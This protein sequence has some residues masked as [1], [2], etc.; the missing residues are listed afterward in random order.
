VVRERPI[1]RP[2]E[3]L[4]RGTVGVGRLPAIHQAELLSEPSLD[5]Q[6]GHGGVAILRTMTFADPD[7]EVAANHDVAALVVL[8]LLAIL[9]LVAERFP[10]ARVFLDEVHDH[11]K[12]GI[13][14]LTYVGVLNATDHAAAQQVIEQAGLF[15]YVPAL[16]VGAGTYLASQARGA[17][18]GPLVEADEDDDLGLQKLLRWVGDLWGGLGPVALIIFPLLTIDVFGLALVPLVL[19]ERRV[20]A[21]GERAKVPCLNCDHSIH[22]RALA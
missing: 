6:V 13:A 20:E 9:E 12:T 7:V 11:L 1:I 21:R 10:E 19:I 15:D 17:V 14:V 22:H 5:C 18:M 16:A 3:G 2:T 8:G 4:G